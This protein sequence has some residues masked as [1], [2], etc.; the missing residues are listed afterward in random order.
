MISRPCLDKACFF[1]YVNRSGADQPGSMHIFFFLLKK[2]E[3]IK[4]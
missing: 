2:H 3:K 1:A 4:K